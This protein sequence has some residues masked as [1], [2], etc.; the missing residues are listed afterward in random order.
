MKNIGEYTDFVKVT[1]GVLQGDVLSPLLFS[2][3]I[4]DFE[5]FLPDQGIQ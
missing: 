4:R 5:S 3:L 2:L 1:S